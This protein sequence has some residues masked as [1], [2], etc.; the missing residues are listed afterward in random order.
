MRGHKLRTK[1]GCQRAEGL[2]LRYCVTALRHWALV[3]SRERKDLAR[4]SVTSRLANG[5]KSNALDALR[6][7]NQPLMDDEI[8]SSLVKVSRC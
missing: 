7:W 4:K 6:A 5:A 3:R 8:V 2:R 1:L